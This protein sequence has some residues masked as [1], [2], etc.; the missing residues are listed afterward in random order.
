MTTTDAFN[1]A[2]SIVSIILALLSIGL[3]LAFFIAAK[4]TERSV[5]SSLTKIETQ[6]EMLQKITGKQLDRLTKFATD[7]PDGSADFVPQMLEVIM[8]LPQA[9]TASLAPQGPSG[10][11]QE[12]L[13]ELL[14]CYVAL[15][16]YAAHT[17]FWCQEHLPSAGDFDEQNNLHCL[18]K[19]IVDMSAIDFQHMEGVIAKIT[20]DRLVEIHNSALVGETREFLARHVKTAADLFVARERRQA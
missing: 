16:F 7:R 13:D 20:P 6:T 10:P 2:A 14:V 17:N 9:L 8:K 19:R 3:S 11:P 1:L 18:V 4:R 5:E 12:L 15:H